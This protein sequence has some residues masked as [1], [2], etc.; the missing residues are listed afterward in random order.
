MVIYAIQHLMRLAG[1]VRIWTESISGKKKKKRR[2]K[3]ETETERRKDRKVET[4]KMVRTGFL[5]IPSAIPDVHFL[6]IWMSSFRIQLS[7]AFFLLSCS[8]AFSFFFFSSFSH[9]LSSFFFLQFYNLLLL[10]LV[11]FTFFISLFIPSAFF[12]EVR[13]FDLPFLGSA[14]SFSCLAFYSSHTL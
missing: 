4:N 7:S 8:L 10:F 13:L 3:R 11:V 14:L 9:F 2:R 6:T 1:M 5:G 12:S